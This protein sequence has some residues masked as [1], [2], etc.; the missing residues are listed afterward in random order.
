MPELAIGGIALAGVI[1]AIIQVAKRLGLPSHLAPWLNGGLSV[2]FYA[3]VVVVA[4]KPDLLQPVTLG[5]NALVIF[6]AAAGFYDR[7]QAIL[8]RD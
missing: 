8:A 4:Q 6:L 2:L 1:V 3:L 7:G 5:L